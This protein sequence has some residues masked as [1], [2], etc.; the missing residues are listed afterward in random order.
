M[1]NLIL[2]LIVSFCFSFGNLPMIISVLKSKSQ[3]EVR[4]LNLWTYTAVMTGS[5]VML[6][7]LMYASAG[8]FPIISQIIIAFVYAILYGSIIYKKCK[9]R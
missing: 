9:F 6:I 8:L 7:L 2:T 1:T 4:V 3:D 5:L